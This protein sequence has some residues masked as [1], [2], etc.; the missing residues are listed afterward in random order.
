MTILGFI[1]IKNYCLECKNVDSNNNVWCAKFRVYLIL[2]IADQFWLYLY[3]KLS[4]CIEMWRFY[5]VGS[6]I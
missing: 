5:W 6:D 2:H 3:N 4:S 1:G